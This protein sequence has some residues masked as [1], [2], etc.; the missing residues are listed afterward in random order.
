MK[1]TALKI[2]SISALLM[3]DMLLIVTGCVVP[4]GAVAP[5]PPEPAPVHEV[6]DCEAVCTGFDPTSECNT[7]LLLLLPAGQFVHGDTCLDRCAGLAGYV[8]GDML[9]AAGSCEEVR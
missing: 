7:E 6:I 1:K 4:M 8:N 3:L 5:P 2:I 9:V